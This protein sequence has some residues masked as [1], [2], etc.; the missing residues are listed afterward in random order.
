MLSSSLRNSIESCYTRLFGLVE[1]VLAFFLIGITF[2]GAE[3]LSG[4]AATTIINAK[5]NL[6]Y[7]GSVYV[8]L[9]TGQYLMDLALNDAW[10]GC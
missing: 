8:V 4:A 10:L 7:E 6:V 1:G 2:W 5:L 3:S 9:L